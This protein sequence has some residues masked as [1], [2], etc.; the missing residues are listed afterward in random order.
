[1][2]AYVVGN[3]ALDET[4]AVASLPAPGASVLARAVSSDL[5]GK[6]VN[7]AVVLGRA[8]VAVTLVTAIGRDPR[9]GEVRARLAAE[10]LAGELIEVEAA[11]DASIILTSEGGENVVVTTHAAADAM[12]PEAALAAVHGATPGDLVIVQGNLSAVTTET[13]LAAARARGVSTTANPSPLRP[14]FAGLWSLIDVAFLNEVE[15]RALGGAEA[16][17]RAGVGRVVVTLGSRGARL[18][19]SD[20]DAHVPAL[21]VEVVDATGAGDCFMATALAS[22]LRREVALDARALSHGVQAA[23]LTVGRAGTARAF[24]TCMEMAAIL[25]TP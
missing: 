2:R 3:A 17:L 8:G 5:G 10:G 11:T 22:A 24:P 16:L 15:E 14:Y 25:A 1:M 6:G 12:T 7:Q 23:A 18:V 21:V 9:G 13:V 4:L 19:S 20:G